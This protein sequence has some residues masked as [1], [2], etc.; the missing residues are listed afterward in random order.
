MLK[1]QRSIL[2]RWIFLALGCMSP[3]SSYIC[4]LSLQIQAFNISLGTRCFLFHHFI[5]TI[6]SQ[7]HTSPL[8]YSCAAENW[9]SNICSVSWFFKQEEKNFW[10]V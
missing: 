3:F 6:L 1:A 9:I 4:V 10:Y 2:T 5:L 8:L 7:E